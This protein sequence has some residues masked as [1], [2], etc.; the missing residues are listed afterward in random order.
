MIS[1]DAELSLRL[2]RSVSSLPSYFHPSFT[3]KSKS[4]FP[5]TS[6]KL[7]SSQLIFLLFP[8]SHLG[9]LRG[10]SQ[11]KI[12][13]LE[14]EEARASSKFDQV[15]QD[16]KINSNQS[17]PLRSLPPRSLQLVSSPC[18]L[19]LIFSNSA[20]LSISSSHPKLR[21]IGSHQ[22]PQ[23]SSYSSLLPESDSRYPIVDATSL[24]NG[25]K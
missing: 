6:S 18:I 9:T 10:Y 21:Q 5:P 25:S 7:S 17:K 22:F 20:Q 13:H 1:T 16:Q 4:F 11:Q 14:S 15:H 23:V 24:E 3:T 8:F 2:L 19:Y 12:S